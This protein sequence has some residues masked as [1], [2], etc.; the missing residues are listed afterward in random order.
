MPITAR[1]KAKNRKTP[2]YLT[3]VFDQVFGGWVFFCFIY[4]PII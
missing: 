3:K 2:I 1:A 4:N